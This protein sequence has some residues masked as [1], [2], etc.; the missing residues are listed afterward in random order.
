MFLV[1]PKDFGKLLISCIMGIFQKLTPKLGV[2][3]QYFHGQLKY[4]FT[5]SNMV[6]HF[7]IVKKILNISS[8]EQSLLTWH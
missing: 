6:F 5:F 2:R 4:G 8:F 7:A 3:L 1:K